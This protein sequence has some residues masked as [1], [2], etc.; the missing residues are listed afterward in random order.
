MLIIVRIGLRV[1]SFYL[2]RVNRRPVFLLENAHTPLPAAEQ[3]QF[4]VTEFPYNFLGCEISNK[5]LL[6]LLL[7]FWSLLLLLV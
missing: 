2:L 7:L 6:L 4:P 5:T 1:S 3:A